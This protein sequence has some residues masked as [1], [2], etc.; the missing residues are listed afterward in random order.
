ME[1]DPLKDENV[2]RIITASNAFQVLS[3]PV[4]LID[5]KSL[6]KHYKV[7]ISI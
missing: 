4:Q 6:K 5:E 3:L 2:E 1:A 7:C